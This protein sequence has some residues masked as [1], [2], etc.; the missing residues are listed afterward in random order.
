VLNVA[1]SIATHMTDYKDIVNKST[2]PVGTADKVT[3]TINA[4]IASAARQSMALPPTFDVVFN[5]EF[6]KE[7]AAVNDFI[8]P[9]RI[10]IGTDCEQAKTIMRELYEPCNRNHD[11]TICMDVRSAELTKYAA[12]P[13]WPPRSAS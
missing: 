11:R 12:K 2:V 1:K 3:A 4:D 7:G 13:C 9:D 6:P 10:I 8:K 5:P